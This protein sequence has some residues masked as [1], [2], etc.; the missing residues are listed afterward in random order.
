MTDPQKK[1]FDTILKKEKDVFLLH[2]ITGSGKTEVYLHLAYENYKQKKQTLIL[3]P[4]IALTP[5]LIAY[6]FKVFGKHISVIHSQLSDGEKFTEW[7]RIKQ[8][9][10]YVVIG[11]RSALFFTLP[12]AWNYHLG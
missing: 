9:E 8:K 11:S 7:V 3:V 12:G 10:S 5:Q 2:G 4:E 6:F 1:A